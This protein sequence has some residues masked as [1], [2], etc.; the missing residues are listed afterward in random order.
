MDEHTSKAAFSNAA[1]LPGKLA[2]AASL[3]ELLSLRDRCDDLS[4]V[5]RAKQEERGLHL[6]S[7]ESS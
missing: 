3:L 7:R 5:C 6:T 1:D 4:F 2:S